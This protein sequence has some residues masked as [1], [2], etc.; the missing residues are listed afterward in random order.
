MRAQDRALQCGRVGRKDREKG[1]RRLRMGGVA[2]PP[3]K[4][5][6]RW[7]EGGLMLREEEHFDL[8]A[9]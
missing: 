4:V 5:S 9:G 1:R 8:G 6:R 3:V 2:A 7:V